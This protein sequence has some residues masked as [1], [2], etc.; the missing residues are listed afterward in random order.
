MA[1]LEDSGTSTAPGGKMPTPSG[2]ITRLCDELSMA[3]ANLLDN[4]DGLRDQL[5]PIL[6]NEPTSMPTES[7]SYDPSTDLG[8]YLSMIISR[9]QTTNDIVADSRSRI[10]L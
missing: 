6:R 4:T 5:G 1:R 10:D 2:E 3:S 9:I 7:K 8:Q